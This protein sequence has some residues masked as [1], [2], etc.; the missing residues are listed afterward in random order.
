LFI[1]TVVV[2]HLRYFAE[3]WSRDS[4]M[5][6]LHH[7]TGEKVPARVPT[8]VSRIQPR[9]ETDL[10]KECRMVGLRDERNSMKECAIKMVELR[11]NEYFWRLRSCEYCEYLEEGE[12]MST[13]E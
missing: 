11:T 2:V 9:D 8:K 4:S 1:A 6:L 12:E 7:S 13:Q 5:E 3:M 10:I